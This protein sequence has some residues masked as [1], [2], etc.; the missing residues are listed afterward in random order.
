MVDATLLPAITATV[1]ANE[2]G[3]GTPYELEYARKDKSG[4]SFGFMQGDT[5]ANALARQTLQD[6]CAAANVDPAAA[7]RILTAVCRGLPHGNP[8]N[9]S[10]TATANGALAS[11]AGRPLVD[12][13]D[14]T[15]MQRVLNDLDRCIA[16]AA[17][18]GQTLSGVAHLFIV[19]WINM[20]GAPNTLM[21]WLKGIPINGIPAPAG[22]EVEGDE[23]SA[24]LHSQ[25]Y[26]Q[27][28][29]KNFKHYVEAVNTGAPLLP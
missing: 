5:N 21:T 17:T 23:V 24:Y 28:N 13:M 7:S 27:N 16:A 9:P 25:T 26:F 2:I 12:A 1:R 15:L 6:V 11:A 20:T 19:P 8:L 22:P 18:R 4:A 10:D 29:P 3:A 14:L